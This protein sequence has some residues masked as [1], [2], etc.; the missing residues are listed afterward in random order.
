[1]ARVV[2]MIEADPNYRT[3]NRR[4]WD[5]LANAGSPYSVPYGPEAFL[6][7]RQTLDPQGWLPWHR[8][9]SV[10]CL[11]SGGGQQG[12]L[13]ASLGLRVTVV[14]ISPEQLARD[15]A[16]AERYDLEI[17]CVQADMLDLRE[18]RGRSFDLVYQPVSAMYVPDVNRLYH[19]VAQVLN[20]GGLYR[21][22][23]W[24]PLHLQVDDDQPWDGWGYRVSRPQTPGVG[25]SWT[26]REQ[27]PDGVW[28]T[29]LHYIHPLQNLVGG[30]PAA[31]FSIRHFAEWSPE[32]DNCPAGSLE[33]MGQY[34][35]TVFALLARRR[36]R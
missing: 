2:H 14:D 16:T 9:S 7:A 20:V 1:M 36:A 30:L 32:A 28:T 8:L 15:R 31:G 29:C 17:E 3:V 22:V 24:N 5:R 35:P 33:H 6:L 26:A 10:L 4:A 34:F 12:P 11:A 18:L 13:F 23:H 19:E 27:D 21:V 25:I